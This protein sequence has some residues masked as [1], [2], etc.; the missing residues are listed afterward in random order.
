MK[1]IESAG[2]RRLPDCV[3]QPLHLISFFATVHSSTLSTTAAAHS[4]CR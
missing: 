1:S 4:Q 2:R 3:K